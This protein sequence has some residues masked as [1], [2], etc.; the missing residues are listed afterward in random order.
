MLQQPKTPKR[1][2]LSKISFLKCLTKKS[3]NN[4]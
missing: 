3:K 1:T 4:T 2:N